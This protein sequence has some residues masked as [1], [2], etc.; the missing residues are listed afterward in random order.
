MRVQGCFHTVLEGHEFNHLGDT[1]ES[2]QK[3]D[4]YARQPTRSVTLSSPEA[5]SPRLSYT[6]Y[7]EKTTRCYRTWSRTR[8]W[9]TDSD[10]W[11]GAWT[12]RAATQPPQGLT[13]TLSQDAHRYTLGSAVPAA[14]AHGHRKTWAKNGQGGNVHADGEMDTTQVSSSRRL[15]QPSGIFTSGGHAVQ[16]REAQPQAA[17]R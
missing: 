7:T 9:P 13:R 3:Q 8:R 5:A 16:T 10:D 14:L 1:L 6:R 15:Y 4:F 11:P 2:L 17:Y 12:Q